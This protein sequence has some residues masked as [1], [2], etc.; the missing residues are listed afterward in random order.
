LEI[1]N[2]DNA[3]NGNLNPNLNSYSANLNSN[4]ETNN[5]NNNNNSSANNNQSKSLNSIFFTEKFKSNKL[6]NFNFPKFIIQELAV[7]LNQ[8]RDI[9][10]S[11]QNAIFSS[12]YRSSLDTIFTFKTNFFQVNR[13]SNEYSATTTK[14]FFFDSMNLFFNHGIEIVNKIPNNNVIKLYIINPNKSRVNDNNN[15]SNKSEFDF[16]SAKALSDIQLKMYELILNYVNYYKNFIL[17]GDKMNEFFSDELANV[18]SST[19]ILSFILMGVHIFLFLGG[20]FILKFLHK[21]I[22]QNDSMLGVSNEEDNLRFMRNKLASIRKLSLLFVENPKNLVLSI[23][24]K[25]AEYMKKMKLNSSSFKES[26]DKQGNN[27]TSKK[28]ETQKRKITKSKTTDE[29]LENEFSS[30]GN[31]KAAAAA[32]TKHDFKSKLNDEF[33]SSLSAWDELPKS[34]GTSYLDK[35]DILV[36]FVYLLLILFALY[37]FYSLIFY[38]LFRSSYNDFM[39]TA[40]FQ[41]K[42]TDLDNKMMNNLNL[43]STMMIL[44]KTEAEFSYDLFGEREGL[45]MMNLFTNVQK[46]QMEMNKYKKTNNKFKQLDEMEQSLMNCSFIYN[47]LND[48]ILFDLYQQANN[49]AALAPETNSTLTL[50]AAAIMR[51]SLTAICELYPFM[52]SNRIDSV[53]G[54]ISYNSLLLYNT[55]KTSNKTY[56]DIN[57]VHDSFKFYDVFLVLL[58]IFRPI[59]KYSSDYVYENII[60]MSSANYLV[61]TIVYLILNIIVDLMIFYVINSLVVK[62]ISDINRHLNNMI[63]CISFKFSNNNKEKKS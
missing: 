62:K 1:E 40:E 51:T 8:L 22:K 63:R 25:K 48:S 42:N 11:L 7:K 16:G 39:L 45:L 56:K 38:F 31:K 37:Y 6:I 53:F 36:P 59:R 49:S 19:Y 26:K 58:M 54:E 21:I 29:A 61:F 41:S 27:R 43:L 28:N 5:D 3:Y 13:V 52:S 20:A 50:N 33:S 9:Y 4:P 14:K 17:I 60:L 46:I 2:L 35:A 44:N 32:Q 55:F 57:D 30:S 12:H 34:K 23:N 18:F 15:N 10:V 47:N 24:K